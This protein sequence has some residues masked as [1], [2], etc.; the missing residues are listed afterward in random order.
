MRLNSLYKLTLVVLS[1][2]IAVLAGCE[3]SYIFPN[4]APSNLTISKPSCYVSVGEEVPLAADAIDEDGDPLYFSWTATVGAFD[5]ADGAGQSVTWIAPDDPGPAVITLIVTDE[6]EESRLQTTIEVGGELPVNIATNEPLG[7]AIADSG[8]VYLLNLQPVVIPDD[9]SFTIMEGVRIVARGRNSGFMVYGSLLIEGTAANPVIMG[10]D[11]CVPVEGS[12]AG[13][14]YMGIE[15]EGTI[16]HLQLHSADIGL[17]VTKGAEISISN[18]SLIN[19]SVYG[20]EVSDGGTATVTGCT[21]W[22]NHTGL[23]MRNGYL[24]LEGSSL[25]YNTIAGIDMSASH[26]SYAP[27]VTNCNVS[28]NSEFG[29]VLSGLMTPQIHNNAIFSNGIGAEACG[30]YLNVFL[31]ADTVRAESNFWGL[32]YDSEEEISALIHDAHD[33]PLALEAFVGFIPWLPVM[34][35]EV[36][37]P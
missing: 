1:T 15:A 16:S 5:P 10:P 14:T 33:E 7:D 34:P 8:Y 25:R 4:E 2:A 32:G 3:D 26:E 9:T 18:S 21:L 23:F 28:N 11:D 31:G 22:E 37:N 12:W 29:F 35:A 17:L 24:T 13:I 27:P 19:N 6:I 30:I 20:M 36:P